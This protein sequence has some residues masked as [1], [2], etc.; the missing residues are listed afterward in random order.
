MAIDSGSIT[1]NP[2]TGGHTGSGMSYEI[3]DNWWDANSSRYAEASVETIVAVKEGISSLLQAIAD[4]VVAE[5]IN[6]AEVTVTV[7]TST[8]GLQRLPNPPN[9]GSATVA[10]ATAVDLSGYIE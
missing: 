2:T 6:N 8:A 9:A 7:T 3:L 1:I 5:I 10:P 4:G